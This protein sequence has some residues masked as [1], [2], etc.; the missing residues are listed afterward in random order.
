RPVHDPVRRGT[1]S[2][3]LLPKVAARARRPR[4]AHQFVAIARQYDLA[5]LDV[6]GIGDASRVVLVVTVVQDLKRIAGQRSALG[7]DKRASDP[8]DD[9]ALRGPGPVS[10]WPAG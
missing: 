1:S 8:V 7:L 4:P 6:V 3:R 2:A 9:P 5:P 10:C